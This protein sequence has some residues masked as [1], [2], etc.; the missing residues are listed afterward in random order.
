MNFSEARFLMELLRRLVGDLV[1]SLLI[2]EHNMRVVMGISDQVAVLDYGE[3]IAEGSPAEVQSDPRVIE[4]YL[5][6]KWIDRA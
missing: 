4:A 5:G 3:K 2:I 6:R 1:Q